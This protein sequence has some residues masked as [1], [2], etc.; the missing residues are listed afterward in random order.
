VIKGLGGF[1]N[2]G[3]MK[4]TY[5]KVPERKPDYIVQEKLNVGA[6]LLYRLNGDLNPLHIDPDRS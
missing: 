5:P 4:I 2:K 6:A 1:G 3:K